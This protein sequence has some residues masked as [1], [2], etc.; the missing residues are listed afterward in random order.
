MRF[1]FGIPYIIHDEPE[2]EKVLAFYGEK[3]GNIIYSRML[4]VYQRTMLSEAQ[5]HKCCWCGRRMTEYPEKGHS[6]TI[7][8]VVPR[9]RGGEDHIDNYAAACNRCNQKRGNH[10]IEVFMECIRTG[11]FKK[12]HQQ[13]KKYPNH[14]EARAAKWNRKLEREFKSNRLVWC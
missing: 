12:C 1:K 7:E 6:T 8:H 5:N 14:L 11:V 2:L 4:L 9:S 13:E 10:S 3:M